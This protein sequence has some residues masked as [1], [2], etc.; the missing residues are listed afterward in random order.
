MSPTP[1]PVVTVRDSSPWGEA[2][3]RWATAHA[4]LVG[5]PLEVHPTT[6]DLV[7]DLLLASTR[8]QLVV[9]PHRGDNGTSFGLG[10]FVL[11]LVQH[12]A[13]DVVVVRGTP[14]ALDGAHRRVTALITGDE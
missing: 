4:Q 9:V 8:A 14:E 7:H 11:P 12:A 5:A 10:R 1:L 6:P 13:S 2:A 3:L